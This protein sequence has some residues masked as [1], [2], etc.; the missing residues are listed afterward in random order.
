MGLLKGVDD[1]LYDGDLTI[2]KDKIF[3][4]C[5]GQGVGTLELIDVYTLV[6]QLE[7]SF[8]DVDWLIEEGLCVEIPRAI[9]YNPHH[10][11]KTLPKVSDLQICKEFMNDKEMFCKKHCGDLSYYDY[12]SCIRNYIDSAIMCCYL[13]LAPSLELEYGEYKKEHPTVKSTSQ[14]FADLVGSSIYTTNRP[15]SNLAWHVGNQGTTAIEGALISDS[16]WKMDY[17]GKANCLDKADACSLPTA[18]LIY[19]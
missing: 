13:S 14:R 16:V 19:N 9:K 6:K 12:D 1:T 10:S 7:I 15:S 4:R 17:D 8:E 3:K 2:I 11:I 5:N 18:Q